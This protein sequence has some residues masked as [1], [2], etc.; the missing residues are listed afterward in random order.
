MDSGLART[1]SQACA[2]CVNLPAL[3][4]PRNDGSEFTRVGITQLLI[5]QT[6]RGPQCTQNCQR[7]CERRDPDDTRAVAVVRSREC[8]ADERIRKESDRYGTRET[9]RRI[10]APAS[11]CD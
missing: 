3:P 6:R 4:A 11:H 7:G 10:E 2:G 8:A 1:R 9:S 5:T